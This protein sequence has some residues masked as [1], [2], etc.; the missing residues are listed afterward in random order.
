MQSLANKTKPELLV[1]AKELNVVGRHKMKREELVRAIEAMQTMKRKQKESL[2]DALA[3]DAVEQWEGSSDV[4]KS[5]SKEA[6]LNNAKIG[7]IVA[8][9]V[10]DKKALSGMITEIHQNG[11][12]VETKSGVKFNVR[13]KNVLWVKTGSRWPKGVYQALKGEQQNECADFSK[14]VNQ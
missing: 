11:F 4:V 5:E 6:Y 1:I 12:V 8:F 2:E 9:K 14:A 7:T 13:R 3:H 10:N